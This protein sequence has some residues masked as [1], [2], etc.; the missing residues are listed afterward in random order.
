VVMRRLRVRGGDPCE[1]ADPRADLVTALLVAFAA[2]WKAF[3]AGGSAVVAIDAI[4]RAQLAGEGWV[5][6]L[7]PEDLAPLAVGVMV[8]AAGGLPIDFLG[9]AATLAARLEVTTG[10]RERSSVQAYA[11]G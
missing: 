10:V 6:R 1:V 11:A 9:I 5:L 3:G 8:A 7:A 2:E 4:V